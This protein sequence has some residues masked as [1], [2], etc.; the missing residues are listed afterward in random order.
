MC[1]LPGAQKP[2]IVQHSTIA[3]DL[4]VVLGFVRFQT[5]AKFS[6]VMR[7]RFITDQKMVIHL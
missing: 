5:K 3:G 6:N 7:T 1:I 2:T 4:H